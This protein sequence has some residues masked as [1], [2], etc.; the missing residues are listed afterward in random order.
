MKNEHP[1]YRHQDHAE[2]V[3]PRRKMVSI[4]FSV[5]SALPPQNP[6][7]IYST[8]FSHL[9]QITTEVPDFPFSNFITGFQFKPLGFSPR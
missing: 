5:F 9:Y 1:V 7:I 2:L 3:I 8:V 4:L 6:R